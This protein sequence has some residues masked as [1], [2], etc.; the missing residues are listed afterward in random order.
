MDVDVRVDGRF[1][2][3][4]NAG[5][6]G[7]FAGN[8]FLV[9][10][11]HV[12][13]DDHLQRRVDEHLQEIGGISAYPVAHFLVRGDEGAD[14]AHIVA[15]EQ[16]CHKC[17]ALDVLVAVFFGEAQVARQTFAYHVPIEPLH[18]HAARVYAVSEDASTRT[19]VYSVRVFLI[20]TMCDVFSDC[21]LLL[22][23][24]YSLFNSFIFDEGVYPWSAITVTLLRQVEP[25]AANVCTSQLPHRMAR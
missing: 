5:E 15:R 24:L 19:C 4:G 11:F 21:W 2:G 6:I 20:V 22:S 18:A 23:L 12:P 1:K 7:D 25:P 14:A 13:V 17:D 10:P 3:V 8:R 16:F 9:Q